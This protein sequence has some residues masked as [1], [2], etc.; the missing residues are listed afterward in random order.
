[1]N[2]L[3]GIGRVVALLLIGVCGI[4]ACFWIIGSLL[5]AAPATG[6]ALHPLTLVSPGGQETTLQ[7][8]W[9]TTEPERELGLMNRTTIDHGML[10]IFDAQQQLT[11]WM[12]N[13]LVPLDVMYFDEHGAFVSAAQM[14]PCTADPCALY[15]S[16]QAAKYALEMPEGFAA[17]NGIGKGWIIHP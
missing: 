13:T 9:A 11:F 6:P 12:K 7:V 10:F 5:S 15:P 14:T 17:Q 8:E 3:S 2:S 1:M 16:R 4:A